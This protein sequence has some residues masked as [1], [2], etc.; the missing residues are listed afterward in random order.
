[1][2][3][4]SNNSG[5]A[6]DPCPGLTLIDVY[7]TLNPAQDYCGEGTPSTI[8]VW[9]NSSTPSIQASVAAGNA[10]YSESD[11][12]TCA[13]TGYYQDIKSSNPNVAH[14]FKGC[15][16]NATWN[17][18]AR[19]QVT[20]RV[21][22]SR[23]PLCDNVGTLVN[24]Y[25]DNS[26]TAQEGFTTN[27]IYTTDAIYG[28]ATTNDPPSIIN[29][30]YLRTTNLSLEEE[31]GVW[32]RFWNPNF[33]GGIFSAPD[34][35]MLEIVDPPTYYSFEV[36]KTTSWLPTDVCNAPTYNY[37]LLDGTYFSDGTRLFS[38]NT[39]AWAPDG[40]YK[41]AG[42]SITPVPNEGE[43]TSN[44]IYQITGGN[45]ILNITSSTCGRSGPPRDFN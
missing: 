20:V 23:S 22:T 13:Q 45:G 7:V 33:G 6:P 30:S 18:A 32:T 8:S 11:C 28:N 26:Y 9:V 38:N 1:M 42:T 4:V 39:G 2:L 27:N 43:D 35:C 31:H 15:A 5:L 21:N 41:D 19:T 3:T 14:Y 29:P 37:Y 44:A 34:Q 40:Y 17:C 12:T 36:H 24:V 25:L 16:W 10:I